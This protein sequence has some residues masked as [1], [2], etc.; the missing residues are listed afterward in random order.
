MNP[1]FTTMMS[2]STTADD[3]E[4]IR[5]SNERTVTSWRLLKANNVVLS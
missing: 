4:V 2:I 3:S 5:G 1:E